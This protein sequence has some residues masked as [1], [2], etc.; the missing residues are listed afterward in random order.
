M[1]VVAAQTVD[2]DRGLGVQPQIKFAGVVDCATVLPC[3]VI[4]ITDGVL[5][6][7]LQVVAA[8]RV[9]KSSHVILMA[10]G[11]AS[12]LLILHSSSRNALKNVLLHQ[13]AVFDWRLCLA[14]TPHH[15]EAVTASLMVLCLSGVTFCAVEPRSFNFGV[16]SL[17]VGTD[18]KWDRELL[19]MRLEGELFSLFLHLHPDCGL[20]DPSTVGSTGLQQIFS[21]VAMTIA[22]AEVLALSVIAP[23]IE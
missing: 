13:D 11:S 17:K 1:R 10:F 14:I 5:G 16:E 9:H 6:Q 3:D 23:V 21:S 8:F 18:D 7:I 22:L 20:P 2:D 4:V 19:V 12:A 15:G